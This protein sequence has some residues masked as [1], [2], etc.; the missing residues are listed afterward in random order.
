MKIG[1]RI[2]EAKLTETDFTQKTPSVVESY[3]DFETV[4]DKNI[5]PRTQNGEYENY[6]LIRNI[7]TA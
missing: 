4:F 7:L 6:Q 2:F 3:V 1:N 5:L